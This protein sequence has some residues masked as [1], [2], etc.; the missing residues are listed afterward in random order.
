M[1]ALNEFGLS[2]YKEKVKFWYDGFR[3]GIQK[4]IYNPW[5][6]L[7]FLS[8]V[9]FKTYWMNTSSNAIIGKLI[10]T[11]GLDIK[12]DCE[13]LLHGGSIVSEL[14]ESITYAELGS[15][16]KT[17]WSWFVTTGYLKIVEA[18]KSPYEA[19]PADYIAESARY[20]DEDMDDRKKFMEDKDKYLCYEASMAKY[21]IALTD[22]EVRVAF[23]G[24]IKKWFQ[25]VYGE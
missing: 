1:E 9:K 13:I 12:R 23:Y 8:E 10:Q 14:D 21:E 25:E 7:N 3:F 20:G 11:G 24:L 5:S 18:K 15:D 19:D 4:D 22:Y 17:I 2:H 6:I 16:S